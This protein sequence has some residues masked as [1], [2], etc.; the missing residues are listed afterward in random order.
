MWIAV[1]LILSAFIIGVFVWSMQ[2]LFQQKKAWG[3]FAKKH[4]YDYSPGKLT[5]SPTIYAQVRGMN[6]SLYTDIQKTNDVRAERFVTI[7]EVA[8]GV[9]FPTGAAIAT[10]E[11]RPFTDSLA[12]TQSYAPDNYPEWKPAYIIRTKNSA[13]LKPYLTR[14]RLEILNALFSMKNSVALF[15]FDEED[16]VLR[17]ETSDPLRQEAHLEKIVKRIVDVCEKLR[18]HAPPPPKVEEQPA[19]PPPS[20]PFAEEP[21]SEPQP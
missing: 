4:N 1:W 9:G 6:L 7:I 2:I 15:F 16:G 21:E 20:A 8:M 17:I 5:A 3:A 10:P 18:P 14:E 11:L 13:A 12:F 19:A